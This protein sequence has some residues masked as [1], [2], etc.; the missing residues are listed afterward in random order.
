MQEK[1]TT[2]LFKL[3]LLFLLVFGGVEGGLSA[4]YN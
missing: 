3:L 4:T 2:N 1:E